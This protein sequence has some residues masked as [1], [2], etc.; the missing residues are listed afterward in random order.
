MKK[1]FTIAISDA[2][3]LCH[4]YIIFTIFLELFFLKDE[5]FTMISNILFSL[6]QV[7]VDTHFIFHP[8][9]GRWKNI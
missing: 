9:Y 6:S 1:H 5:H 7:E 3:R 8:V 4:A 2:V